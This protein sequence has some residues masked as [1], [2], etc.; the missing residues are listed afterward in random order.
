MLNIVLAGGSGT[1]LW[2]L[3]RTKFPKQFLPILEG[4]SLFQQTLARNSTL[5]RKTI[6]VANYEH[7]FIANSQAQNMKCDLTFLL[8]P[9]GRNTAV[10]IAMACMQA[11]DDELV[12]VTPSDHVVADENSYAIAVADA[13]RLASD[14]FIVTF[15]VTPK[16]AETGFGYIEYNGNDVIS[17]R[18]KPDL[19]TAK[20]YLESGRYLWNSGIFCFR[21]DI[22]LAELKKHAF[23]IYRD[24]CSVYDKKNK[25]SNNSFILDEKLLSK[26][27][28]ESIDYAVMEKTDMVRVVPVEMG[29]SDLGSF[30]ALYEYFEKDINDNVKIGDVVILNSNGNF[31]YGAKNKPIFCRNIDNIIVVDSGDA[32]LV[33]TKGASQTIKELLPLVPD[34]YNK[35]KEE[36]VI[37]YRPW[38]HYVVLEDG[39][40]FK[41][42][43]VT[44]KTACRLS[45]QK[46]LHRNEHWVIVKG[47]AKIINGDRTLVLNSNESTYIPAGC[48]HRIEN[49]GDCDLVFTETQVGSYLGED[50]IVRLEDDYNR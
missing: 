6:V 5:C 34:K 37:V 41:I 11:G 38:G 22:Y 19:S 36:H 3:S 44:V 2:P 46:H 27:R 28:S 48:I 12:L 7:Y 45:L 21:T 16:Y 9:I 39:I 1:R 14:G 33:T 26:I 25:F 20:L 32:I 31:I 24:A 18:E 13:A 47:S 29:W 8:E 23:D 49:I 42:K 4:S 43:K 10:A 50:D 40:E 17:F 35:L 15:G 30:D